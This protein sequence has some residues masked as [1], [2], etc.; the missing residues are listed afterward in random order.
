MSFGMPGYPGQ[1]V[2]ACLFFA[3]QLDTIDINH[4][5]KVLHGLFGTK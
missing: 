1:A 4:T 5:I 3:K 2:T